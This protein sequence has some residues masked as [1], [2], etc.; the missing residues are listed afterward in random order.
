[1]S[2]P[3]RR[4]EWVVFT[5]A[6]RRTASRARLSLPLHPPRRHLQRPA[7]CPR[8]GRRHLQVEGLPDQ[9]TRP[10]QEHDARR[11]RVH[12]PLSPAR[13]AERLRPHPHYGLTLRARNIER[14]R[15]ALAA[16]KVSPQSAPAEANSETEPPS[17]TH[18]CPCCGGRMIIIE[19]FEGPPR[20]RCR[21]TGSGSTLHDR[22]RRASRLA[23]PFLFAFRRAPEQES[24]AL[25]RPAHSL[26]VPRPRQARASSRPN[27]LA[28]VVPAA[29][30]GR[31][32]PPPRHTRAVRDPQ[33][34]IARAWPTSALP[35][36]VSPFGGLRTPAPHPAP[37][38]RNGPRPKPF[39]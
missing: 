39:T 36:R 5:K 1:M 11:R 12:P 29:N 2:A 31:R 37:P 9:R 34:P 20:A 10:A 8:R 6:V 30:H 3:L 25:T 28:I 22:R 19:T 18:R 27:K 24:V 23:T 13:A 38:S 15:Q 21:R 33:I 7:H 32:R 35:P 4:S 16:P 14:A 26:P 17:P